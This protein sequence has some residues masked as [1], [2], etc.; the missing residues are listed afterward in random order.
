MDTLAN[1][2]K[3]L[4]DETLGDGLGDLQ[5]EPLVNTVA[6]TVSD[7]EAESLGQD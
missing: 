5:A 1:T 7:I 3:E 2:L 4:E 6:D